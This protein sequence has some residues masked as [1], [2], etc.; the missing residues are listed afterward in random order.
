MKTA[1]ILLILFLFLPLLLRQPSQLVY[2]Q[3]HSWTLEELITYIG[4]DEWHENGVLGTGIKVGVLDLGFQDANRITERIHFPDGVNAANILNGDQVHGTQILEI[5]HA[6]APEAEFYL[7]PLS[8][9]G[10]NVSQAV[11]WLIEQEVQVVVFAASTLDLPLNGQNESARQMDRLADSGAVVVVSAGNH[12]CSILAD[13]FQDTNGDGWHE[14][15]GGYSGWGVT[16]LQSS[17]FGQAHL[18]WDDEWGRAS[19]DLDLYILGADA[20]TVIAAST[21]IQNGSNGMLPFEDTFFN[22]VAGRQY[23]VAIRAKDP[24]QP[25]S[26]QFYLFVDDAVL[27]E[28]PMESSITA[29]GD[30]TQAITVGGLERDG[31]IYDRSGRGPTWDGR[32]KPELVAPARIILNGRGF[33][34]EFEGTSAATPVVAGAVALLR[35]YMPDATPDEIK[36]YLFTNAHDIVAIGPDFH[37]GYGIVSIPFPETE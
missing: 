16:P 28:I 6:I 17:R 31:T 11:D 3:S 1:Q 29:P 9:A 25:I 24:S 10:D 14:Y 37:S 8:P 26:A 34:Y 36:A 35:Q 4:A 18:R 21:D 27:S 7:Y 15:I 2:A 5:I 30:S 13:T 33:T 23:Y 32:L 20:R 12:G 19:I 22:M